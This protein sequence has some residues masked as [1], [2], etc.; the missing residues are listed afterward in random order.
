[1][2][3]PPGPTRPVGF[4]NFMRP[5]GARGSPPV[6]RLLLKPLLAGTCTTRDLVS[7]EPA[8]EAELRSGPSRQSDRHDGVRRRHATGG[9][10]RLTASSW[11]RGF[12][13]TCSRVP[14]RL[15]SVDGVVGE[16]VWNFATLHAAASSGRR[17][18]R[19]S[20]PGAGRKAARTRAPRWPGRA[21]DTNRPAVA[22]SSAGRAPGGLALSRVTPRRLAPTT[23]QQPD[24]FHY[25]MSLL[26]TTPTS[27]AFPPRRRDPVSRGARL[28]RRRRPL[29]V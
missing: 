11:S 3:P 12:Q 5:T 18:R 22:R 20:S 23:R 10:N 16:P 15:R 9:C 7:A 29:R 28:R 8:L 2:K 6:R 1:M 14:P 25:F 4:A 26:S 24:V 21:D 13:T 19:A 27:S 17:D